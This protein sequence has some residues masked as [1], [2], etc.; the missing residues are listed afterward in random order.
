MKTV[1]PNPGRKTFRRGGRCGGPC[2]RIVEQGHL[3][4]GQIRQRRKMLP[5]VTI[6]SMGA[7]SGIAAVSMFT[8]MMPTLLPRSWVII[9]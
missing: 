2:R 3:E 8:A 9:R 4:R 5:F 7:D 6:R 1:N